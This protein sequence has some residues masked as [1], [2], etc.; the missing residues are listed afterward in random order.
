[1]IYKFQKHFAKKLIELL[2][3]PCVIVTV[4]V[5]V[6]HQQLESFLVPAEMKGWYI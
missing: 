4:V 1:M 2:C 3:F 5:D 6:F